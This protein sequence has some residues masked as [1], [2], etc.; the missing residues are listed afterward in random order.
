MTQ[1]PPG[2]SAAD[3]FV[4]V[5]ARTPLLP[6]LLII[7]FLVSLIVGGAFRFGDAAD[8]AAGVPA[9]VLLHRSDTR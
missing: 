2:R 6:A 4:A 7:V 5:A 9:A 8:A 3:R 1:P